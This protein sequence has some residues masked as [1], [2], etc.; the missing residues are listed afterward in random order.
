MI[1]PEDHDLF[2]T[3]VE[4]DGGAVISVCVSA[5]DIGTAYVMSMNFARAL[6]KD[7]LNVTGTNTRRVTGHMK[8]H[9][10]DAGE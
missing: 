9:R 8:H 1:D 10:E 5:P 4:A 7:D 2:V 3:D 6:L